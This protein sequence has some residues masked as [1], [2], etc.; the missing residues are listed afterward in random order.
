MSKKNPVKIITYSIYVIIDEFFQ[1]FR[2]IFIKYFW[3]PNAVKLHMSDFD[4]QLER[5]YEQRTGR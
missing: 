5:K 4:C 1:Y 3:T 2:S